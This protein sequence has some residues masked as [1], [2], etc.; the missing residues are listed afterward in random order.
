MATTAL[1]S[2]N[3]ASTSGNLT[4]TGNNNN[5]ND[6]NGHVIEDCEEKMDEDDEGMGMTRSQFALMGLVGFDSVSDVGY[7]KV[8]EVISGKV[9]LQVN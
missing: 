4:P 1:A 6:N 9:L 5:I 7:N 8:C 2:F 3:G